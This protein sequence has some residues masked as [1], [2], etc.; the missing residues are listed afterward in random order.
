MLGDAAELDFPTFRRPGQ[1]RIDIGPFVHELDQLLIRQQN[2]VGH[3][4]PKAVRHDR[5]PHRGGEGRTPGLLPHRRKVDVRDP[6]SPDKKALGA[7]LLQW[8]VLQIHEDEGVVDGDRLEEG[9]EDR[10]LVRS[11]HDPGRSAITE[12]VVH[13]I[14]G[15]RAVARHTIQT[16]LLLERLAVQPAEG[17]CL[18][19]ESRHGDRG[20]V[21]QAF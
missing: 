4:R 10:A 16:D 1:G 21:Q 12:G 17:D 14:F 15:V 6:R 5:F 3:L 7:S 2:T 8:R 13:V 9:T 18:E 11:I 20:R 19:R